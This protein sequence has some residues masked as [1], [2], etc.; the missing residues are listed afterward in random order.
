MSFQLRTYTVCT[1]VG[2]PLAEFTIAIHTLSTIVWFLYIF[3][4]IQVS[5]TKA[6]VACLGASLIWIISSLFRDWLAIPSPYPDCVS[7]LV[8]SL[9]AFPQADVAFLVSICVGIILTLELKRGS[10]WE[11]AQ[12]ILYILCI[13]I[14]VLAY[15]FAF[16][17]SFIQLGGTALYSAILT[18]IL[19][20]L[21]VFLLVK[22][23]LLDDE[24]WL[25]DRTQF[26]EE[27]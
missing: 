18:I 1:I 4:V 24:H 5:S 7:P 17:G 6:Y 11:A 27:C 3:K 2:D 9:Y 21:F 25:L 10:A 16:L 19:F 14:I 20:R 23:G 22:L 13:C 15:Y 8:P 26:S 12:I